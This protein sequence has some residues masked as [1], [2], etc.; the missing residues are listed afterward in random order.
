MSE[1]TIFSRLDAKK[2]FYQIS[3]NNKSSK[4]TTFNTPL[5]RYC[6]C[7][8]PFGLNVAPEI[9]YK[10]FSQ[11]LGLEGVQVYMDDIIVSGKNEAEHRSRLI[12]VM[13]RLEK[14]NVKLNKDKCEWAVSKLIFIGHEFS[15][16]GVRPDP[17]KVKAN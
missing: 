17:D 16:T 9:F 7:K 12:K 4:L 8:L 5:G 13:Q 2:G 6:F 14:N 11:L 15:S 3:L 10:H 1:A